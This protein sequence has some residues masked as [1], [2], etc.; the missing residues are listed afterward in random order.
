MNLNAHK[1]RSGRQS[2]KRSFTKQVAALCLFQVFN[3]SSQTDSLN[4]LPPDTSDS[5][6]NIPIFST[7]GADADSDMDQQDVSSLLQ[8]S[9]DVF[10]QFASFQFGPSRY[11]MRGYALE[12]QTIMING[13]N[14]SNLETG[15][16]SWGNWGGLNDVTRFSEIR[17]GNLGSRYNFSG[18]GGYTNI[19]S[20]ASSFK[21]G[22][23]VSYATSNRVFRHRLMATHS[24]GMMRNG[25]AF[26]ASASSRTGEEVYIP[27]TYFRANAFYFSADKKLN[28]KN[29]LSFTGF[30]APTEQGRA[31]ALQKE[32]AEISGSNYYNSAWGYQN[33]K[34]RNASVN[35]QQRPMLM[36]SHILN[37][38]EDSRLTSTVFYSFGKAS[39]TNLNWNDAANPRPDYYRYLPSYYALQNNTDVAG[40]ITARWQTDVNTRQI[41]WDKM[42]AQ[43]QINFYTDPQQPFSVP[44]T[45]ET[46]ARYILE[47]QVEDLKNIGFNSVYNARFNKLYVSAGLNANIFRNRKYKELEDLLGA[48]FWIDVDQFAEGIGVDPLFAQNNVDK[49]NQKVYKN[50]RF[51]YD[52]STNI[53][54]AELWGQAEY[55]FKKLDLYGGLSVSNNTVWREG[56]VANGKFPTT[57]KGQSKHLN[58]FNYGLKGGFTYKITGR[59][60]ITGGGSYLTRTPEVSNI[61]LSPRVRN[62]AVSGIGS[63]RLYS[64][65]INYLAKFTDFRLRFTLY[66]TQINN[67]VWVRTFW[68]DAYNNNVNMI[69]K[70]VNQTHQGMELGVEKIFGAHVLQGAFGY[71]N[72]YYSN[73]PTLEAWQDN[74]NAPL[75][76]GRTVYIKNYRVGGSPQLVSG[77]G[78]KYNAKRHWFAGVF[79][80]YCANTYIEPNPDRRTAESAGKFL[81]TETD[82]A[83]VIIGQEKL[84]AYFTVNAFGG[85]SFRVLGKYFLNL[86][87][88]INNLLNNKTILVSGFEQLRWDAQVI[89]RFPNKYYYM[90]G[91]TF[92]ASLNFNF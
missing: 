12:N 77:V 21:K 87:L 83:N 67:Q 5:N 66:H 45:T 61:F 35:R 31:N 58:F 6:F 86:N 46:R 14:V 25:W 48:T 64:G 78:Y 18:A 50:D 72:F 73:R 29:L 1:F 55:S 70:G 23:R 7:T 53:N 80:N 42:I 20:K 38:K 90:P 19:D 16:S 41:N 24:T 49:P 79:F 69:M 44:N 11:R 30:V 65:D 54:R 10:V 52:Y 92:M 91:T 59:H 32:V 76:N 75:F 81:T 71:G 27:G 60:F 47:N 36:L 33:G 2:G 62:D 39:R 4:N 82:Q 40:S 89:E 13:V 26:T 3:L 68:H 17:F 28:A 9:R 74:N 8:S 57:S 34:V 85:K 37:L 51:G 56:Y 22:T 15:V 88:S 84:P 43:N 63:E